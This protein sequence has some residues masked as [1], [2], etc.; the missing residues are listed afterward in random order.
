MSFF[1]IFANLVSI[2]L[3]VKSLKKQSEGVQNTLLQTDFSAILPTGNDVQN[4]PPN[5]RIQN[6]WSDTNISIISKKQKVLSRTKYKT[7]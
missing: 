6:L 2:T 1:G 7:L 5:P 4:T 3:W